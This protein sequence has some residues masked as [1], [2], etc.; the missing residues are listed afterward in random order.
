M[1]NNTCKTCRF[2]DYEYSRNNSG[3][4]RI[5]PPVSAGDNVWPETHSTDWCGQHQPKTQFNAAEQIMFSVIDALRIK[6]GLNQDQVDKIWDE[7]AKLLA[8]EGVA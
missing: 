3:L 4:C 2:W 7:A 6:A 5:N 8:N 1:T